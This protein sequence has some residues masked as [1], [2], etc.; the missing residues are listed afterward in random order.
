MEQAASM[1]PGDGAVAQ[2]VRQG[3]NNDL[4]RVSDEAGALTAVGTQ[5]D[6][7]GKTLNAWI[8]QGT[9]T[10]HDGDATVTVSSTKG[11]DANTPSGGVTNVEWKNNQGQWKRSLVVTIANWHETREYREVDEGILRP[12]DNGTQIVDPTTLSTLKEDGVSRTVSHYQ[13]GHTTTSTL[14]VADSSMHAAGDFQM[15]STVPKD[16]GANHNFV[17]RYQLS[18]ATLYH[19]V[20]T[21]LPRRY[22][23]SWQVHW[24]KFTV[25]SP[26]KADRSLAMHDEVQSDKTN[27]Q[28]MTFAATDTTVQPQGDSL[29]QR[30]SGDLTSGLFTKEGATHDVKE[31]SSSFDVARQ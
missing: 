9:G 18:G 10:Y 8:A 25:P 16:L 19:E 24:Q 22:N 14:W 12:A 5:L 7:D 11:T 17:E 15:E 23:E 29:I 2:Q 6:Q 27:W 30:Q 26:D 31:Q 28:N 21:R 13:G 4:T 3:L 1:S 20:E